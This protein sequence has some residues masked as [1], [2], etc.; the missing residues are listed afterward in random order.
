[1]RYLF[2]PVSLAVSLAATSVL[3]ADRSFDVEGFTEV[4]VG[5]GL[6]VEITQGDKFEVTA[7]G[8]PKALRRLEIDKRGDRLLIERESRGLERF[9]P[10]L[11]AI[12]DEVK[13]WV[14]LPEFAA[15]EAAAG[16][17]V[18]AR[19]S[20][21]DAFVAVASSGADLTLTGIDAE[22]VTL[23]A[24][25]GA[26]L[27]AEGRCDALGA[28]AGSGANLDARGLTCARA[29]VRASSGADIDVTAE[30]VR[31]VASSGADVDVW[32][33]KTVEADESSGGDVSL[34]R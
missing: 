8:T 11:M 20:A 25:S 32:G 24:S 21:S 27:E 26:G 30:D 15:V 3:A 10:L 5:S 17:D 33:A 22:V 28:E 14:T 13:V 6:D 23:E 4:A 18:E 7:E 16:S 12:G 2:L 29:S 1:M 9:S 19:G 34:H 31:A